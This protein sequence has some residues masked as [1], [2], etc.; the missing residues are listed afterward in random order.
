MVSCIKDFEKS[1]INTD[2]DI[3]DYKKIISFSKIS[4]SEI[5]ADSVTSS[6]IEVKIDPNTTSSNKVIKFF[7]KG[8]FFDNGDTN[9]VLSA[10]HFGLTTVSFFSKNTG[11]AKISA[12]IAD[13]SIDTIIKVNTAFPDYF[14]FRS[15]SYTGLS[16][17]VFT[18]STLLNR[19]PGRGVVSN[20]VSIEYEAVSGDL[21]FNKKY[22]YPENGIASAEVSNPFNST[23]SY[24]IY[25][26]VPM[27]DGKIQKD[28]LTLII[29]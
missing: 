14:V 21:R 17:S 23:G 10:N 19:K 2:K 6:M 1:Y 22:S 4:K 12:T 18:V 25:V 9:K 11:I 20:D 13:I 26:K 8:G 16:T 28:S 29:Q 24:K 15:N 27:S 7:C 5:E 3:I